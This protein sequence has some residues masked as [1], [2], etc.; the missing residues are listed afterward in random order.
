MLPAS[1]VA[2]SSAYAVKPVPLLAK[3]TRMPQYIC[4]NSYTVTNITLKHTDWVFSTLPK[5]LCVQFNLFDFYRF[6]LI[7]SL[8]LHWN[9]LQFTYALHWNLLQFTYAQ[10]LLLQK[11]RDVIAVLWCSN[12]KKN[13]VSKRFC[14]EW[15]SNSRPWDYETHALP[16]APS[17]LDAIK[18][19]PQLNEA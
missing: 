12:L 14:P 16:T 9:L 11:C 13:S 5:L 7:L 17:R 10:S 19:D 3:K 8:K 1:Y 2:S 18:P 6:Q 15:G 4:S